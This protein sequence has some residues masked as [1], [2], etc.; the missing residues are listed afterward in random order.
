MEPNIPL[1]LVVGV[2]QPKRYTVLSLFEGVHVIDSQFRKYF[3]LS[4]FHP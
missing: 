1:N 2:F 4:L 3:V